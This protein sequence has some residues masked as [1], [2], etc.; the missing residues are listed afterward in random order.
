[1]LTSQMHFSA[2]D[3]ESDDVRAFLL[4][5]DVARSRGERRRRGHLIR[6]ARRRQMRKSS[7]SF[8]L[9]CRRRASALL[10][11]ACRPALRKE[12][13]AVG[14]KEWKTVYRTTAWQLKLQF[15]RDDTYVKKSKRNP[16]TPERQ[17]ERV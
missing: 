14:R 6:L 4:L 3:Y 13:A 16:G 15:S 8:F 11:R 1:M 2:G 5:Q 12:K 9:P 10:L 7:L 17:V